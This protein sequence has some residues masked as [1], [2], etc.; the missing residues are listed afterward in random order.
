MFSPPAQLNAEPVYPGVKFLFHLFLWG[1]AYL[2]GIICDKSWE[3]CKLEGLE[4]K[5]ARKLE[6]LT[7][8]NSQLATYNPQHPTTHIIS[9]PCNSGRWY[10]G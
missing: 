3:A 1:G 5:K 4:A 6:G 8:D 7:I 10:W 2:I 9:L